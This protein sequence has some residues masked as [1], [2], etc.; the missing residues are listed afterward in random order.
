MARSISSKLY[1][2]VA[3]TTIC[4][5]GTLHR[6]LLL[7]KAGAQHALTAAC[8]SSG[9]ANVCLYLLDHTLSQL[10]IQCTYAVAEVDRMTSKANV[11]IPPPTDADGDKANEEG[12]EDK[13]AIVEPS[14]GESSGLIGNEE[15]IAAVTDESSAAPGDPQCAVSGG[16]ENERAGS[17]GE[18][19]EPQDATGGED[20]KDEKKEET[21]EGEECTRDAE[22]G[23]GGE[24]SHVQWY[25][26]S[27]HTLIFSMVNVK[28][29]AFERRGLIAL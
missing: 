6:H 16:G 21:R 29:V 17:A 25:A 9:C 5:Y 3:E 18:V 22:H 26:P 13:H 24:A 15:E 20:L 7:C 14:G 10:C 12:V 8:S 2:D 4:G 27:M 23:S 1:S 28:L 19:D 11:E